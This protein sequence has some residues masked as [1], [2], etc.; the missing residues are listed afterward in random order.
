MTPAGIV[1]ALLCLLLAAGYIL[2]GAV[3]MAAPRTVLPLYRLM[4]GRRRFERNR[5]RFEQLSV[6]N[7]KMM[8]AAYVGF[9]L[10]LLWA[11][12]GMF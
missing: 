5:W 8:G 11:L 10:I 12:H 1:L 9:G 4:L 7:W 2:L 6:A 3:Q